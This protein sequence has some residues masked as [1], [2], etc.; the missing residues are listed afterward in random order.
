MALHVNRSLRLPRGEYFPGI[1]RKSG[2]AIHHTVGGSAEAS[3]RIWCRDRSNGGRPNL[4]GTAYIIGHDGTVFEIFSPTAWAYQFGLPWPAAARL[5]FER[6]FIG[7]EIASEGALIE[8]DGEL[9]CFDRISSRTR[10]PKDQAFDAGHAYRGYRWFDRYEP[11]QIKSLHNLVDE[12]CTRFAIPRQYPEQPFEYY[13]DRLAGFQ[14]V[15]GHAMVRSDKTDPAPDPSLWQALET[16]A[17]LKPTPVAP[18]P[19]HRGKPALSSLEIEA[20]FAQNAERADEMHVAAGSLVKG[21]L[22]ELERRGIYVRLATPGP[23]SHEIGYKV[24][25]GD[26]RHVPPIARALG[27]KTVTDRLLEVHSAA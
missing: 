16:A 25:Q 11:A 21:L 5:A 15:I 27:F 2:I 7:I 13:G 12:L 6:R 26:H 10:K 14:G 17:G 1:Q 3:V 24:I 22:M 18:P 8:Q 20:L 4:V 19:R 23:G 9:Y